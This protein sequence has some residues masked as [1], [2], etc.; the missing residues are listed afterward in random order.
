M[1]SEMGPL[2]AFWGEKKSLLAVPAP[3][4]LL[5]DEARKGLNSKQA[6]RTCGLVSR[7]ADLI[8][9][10]PPVAST[11]LLLQWPH[12]CCLCLHV[13][14]LLISI[15]LSNVLS[16]PLCLSDAPFIIA[17]FSPSYPEIG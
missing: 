5:A 6:M 1:A 15:G 2:M 4:L 12:S 14:P 3:A 13:F 7:Q 9:P 8:S 11:P 17:L 16:L 10:P